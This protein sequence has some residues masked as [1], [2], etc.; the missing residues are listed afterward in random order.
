MQLHGVP[1]DMKAS[2]RVVVNN[3]MATG[4][5]RLNVLR[6]GT[7]V[8]D[9]ENDLVAAKLYF[10]LKGVVTAPTAPRIVRLH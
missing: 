4:G 7:Q 2:Y 8:Q 1:L 5:D 10:R 9:G 3:Y 6:H